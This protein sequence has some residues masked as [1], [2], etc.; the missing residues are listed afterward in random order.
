M[1]HKQTAAAERWRVISWFVM[2][3]KSS[4]RKQTCDDTDMS[5]HS[6]SKKADYRLHDQCGHPVSM[7]EL[8]LLCIVATDGYCS[9][10]AKVAMQPIA[11]LFL[12]SAVCSGHPLPV[13]G[14]LEG[15]CGYFP[16]AIKTFPDN[17]EM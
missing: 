12:T 3:V 9:Q 6:S 15:R 16:S 13:T 4:V 10:T 14:R 1:T 11:C 7:Q 5:T 17:T 8:P 2:V